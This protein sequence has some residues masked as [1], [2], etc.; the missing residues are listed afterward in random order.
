MFFRKGLPRE[1]TGL[2]MIGAKPGQRVLFVGD[3][4]LDLAAAVA[5]VTG[6]NGHTAVADRAPG[7]AARVADAGARAGALLEHV[8]AP[9]AMLPVDDASFDVVVVHAKLAGRAADARAAIVGE[10]V[11]AVRAGGRV[12]VVEGARRGGLFGLAA[13]G[14]PSIDERTGRDLLERAGALAVR[15]LAVSDGVA[16]WEGRR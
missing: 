7:L 11:R 10:A 5:L 9:P 13:G 12:I 2:A 14:A 3:G 6:L 4:N 1:H 8:D 16:Y 15:Q